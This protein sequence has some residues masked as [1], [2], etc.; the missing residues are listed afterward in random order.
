MQDPSLFADRRFP[1]VARP[2]I[3]K[4]LNANS[5]AKTKGFNMLTLFEE[6]VR[7]ISCTILNIVMEVGELPDEGQEIENTI[8]VDF[9][10]ISE[11]ETNRPVGVDVLTYYK[12]DDG[13]VYSL[14]LTARVLFDIPEDYSEE[15]A[16]EYLAKFGMTRAF[17][18]V[19]HHIEYLTNAAGLPMADTP[20]ILVNSDQ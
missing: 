15:D 20:S 10:I 1:I 4:G 17:D 8:N 9:N 3:G 5:G 13:S 11:T 14:D 6:R 12:I 2:V 19:R 16:A 18:S 7:L